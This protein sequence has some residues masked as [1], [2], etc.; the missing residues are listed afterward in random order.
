VTLA[1]L[2]VVL[3]AVLYYGGVYAVVKYE[4][5]KRA[6]K[7]QECIAK[8]GKA[9]AKTD[10]FDDVVKKACERDP[11]DPYAEFGPPIKPDLKAVFDPN[12]PY[13]STLP[14]G[15]TLDPKS[16]KPIED[17]SSQNASDQRMDLCVH[18]TIT[19]WCLAH[20]CDKD[21]ASALSP[22]VHQRGEPLECLQKIRK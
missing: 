3:P 9:A 5:H 11:N 18:K 20:V 19:D 4:G 1:L 10:I 17:R 14:A 12:A 15:Y 22:Q 16:W 21:F 7:V 6:R 2:L 13:T 8:S